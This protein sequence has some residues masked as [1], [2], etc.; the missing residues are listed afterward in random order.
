MG[1]V[2]AGI[3]WISCLVYASLI[4]GRGSGWYTVDKLSDL[5]QSYWWAWF[6]GCGP[7]VWLSIKKVNFPFLGEIFLGG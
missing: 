2:L 1:V 7:I 4:D 3:Q 6:N 5:C